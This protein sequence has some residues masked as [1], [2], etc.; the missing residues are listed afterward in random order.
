[1]SLTPTT[2]PR[3]A[4]RRLTA[5]FFEIGPKNLLRLAEIVDVAVAAE[6]AGRRHDVS[7]ILTVP[8]PLIAPVRA[9][10]PGVFVFAQSMDDDEVGPSVGTV[11]AETLVDA[12]ADGVM[13][14]HDSH[15]LDG[16][17]LDRAIR[18]ASTNG[19]LTM[20]CAGSDDEAAALALLSPTVVLY[21]PPALIGTSGRT[22]R[23]WISAIDERMRTL[24]PSVLMMHAGGVSSPADVYDIM[25]VGA[26][27][28]G[29]TSG[30]LGARSPRDAAAEFIE[31]ARRGF[32]AAIA[33]LPA[34]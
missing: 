5:P 27:G 26:S 8:A 17:S 4:R 25:K 22:D 24:A 32:D 28:T 16:E 3:V 34:P 29:S 7:V 33:R 10:V 18:R 21:E 2:A 11:I 15:P 20:V 13:L 19:L 23:H 31:A 9:A 1:M 12:G 6:A 30:V 14:N